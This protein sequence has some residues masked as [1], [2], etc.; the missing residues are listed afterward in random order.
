MPANKIMKQL[1]KKRIVITCIIIFSLLV[2]GG[3]GFLGYGIYK[4]TEA[5]DAKKLLSS[6]A[7]VMYDKN[8]EAIYT[9]GSEENGTRENNLPVTINAP[10]FS[11]FFAIN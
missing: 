5:F 10:D 11:C 6:G 4:D 2:V 7:S 3:I 9:Y 1:N 8:G